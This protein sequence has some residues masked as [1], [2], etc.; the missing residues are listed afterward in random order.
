MKKANRFEVPDGSDPNSGQVPSYCDDGR[1][2]QRTI[3]NN[4]QKAETYQRLMKPFE[5]KGID[6]RRT[7]SDNMK[8]F[9]KNPYVDL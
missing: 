1:C 5:S 6:L 7:K 2:Q 4:I 8:N 9:S 3:I